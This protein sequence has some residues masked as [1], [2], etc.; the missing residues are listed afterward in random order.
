M[1]L[2]KR[3]DKKR[4]L[5][6][7]RH[8]RGRKKIDGSAERPRLSLFKGTTTFYAQLVDDLSGKTIMG[9]ATNSKAIKGQIKGNNKEAAAAF[10]KAFAAKCKE[11]GVEK[12]VFDRGGFKYHGVIKAFADSAREA[13]LKF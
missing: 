13:G 12:V 3:T 6:K 11:K 8:I 2:L 5:R 7:I 4:S 9:L 1:K 10:G